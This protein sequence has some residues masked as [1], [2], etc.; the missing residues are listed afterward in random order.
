MLGHTVI[1]KQGFG[2]WDCDNDTDL[3][4]TGTVATIIEVEPASYGGDLQVLVAA[5]GL[6]DTHLPTQVWGLAHDLKKFESH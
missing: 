5:H 3:L 2:M 6:N 1:T 4:P